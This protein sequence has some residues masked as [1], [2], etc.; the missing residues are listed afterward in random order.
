MTSLK[1]WLFVTGAAVSLSMA[2]AIPASAAFIDYSLS[3]FTGGGTPP[4]GPYGTVDLNDH[5]GANVE[6]TVTL[7]SGEGFVNSGAGAALTCDLTGKPVATITGLN[8][9]DFSIS[10]DGTSTGNLDGTGSWF[11][12]IDCTVSACGSG[13]NAPL[14]GTPLDFTIDN[15]GLSSFISNN[16]TENGYYFASDICTSVVNGGCA[17]ITG[18]VVADA[19]SAPVPEPASLTLLAGGLLVL[20][21]VLRRREGDIITT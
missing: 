19:A 9:T 13:G 15:V 11:Y 17:G 20:A 5:G 3:Q 16:K 6:V 18:D 14:T 10:H 4:A 21:Y 7:T 2:M 12:E 8:S 1:L